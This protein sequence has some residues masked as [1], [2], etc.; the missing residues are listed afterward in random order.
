M[1]KVFI[2]G[3]AGT[4]GLKIKERLSH[5]SDLQL[6]ILPDHLRKDPLAKKDAINS[7]DVTFLCL[8]DD[9]AKESV[10]LLENE[11]TVIIDTS[12]AHRVNDSFVYG[13]P[14]IVGYEKVKKAKKI[15]NPGCHASGFIALIAP[16]VKNGIITKD[17]LLSCTS[18]TGYSGGGKN[19]IADYEEGNNSLNEA[20]RL[21][22]LTQNHKHLK[23]MAHFTLLETAPLFLPI[24]SNF[25]SGMQVTVPL[26]VNQINGDMKIISDIYKECYNGPVVK[27]VENADENGFMS[28]N[29]LSGTDSMEIT[30]TGNQDK[31]LLTARYDNLGKGASGSAI[32]NMNIVLGVNET[33]G[34]NLAK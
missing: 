33:I 10:G 27:F 2:D 5:R 14:E 12:T 26:F 17:A 24:V 34:L 13:F 32:Q 3:S 21:Y 18:L 11:N 6:I 19:M 9:A 1:T 16:L 31:I 25:Y 4:T 22:G 23:E 7:S 29:K 8:P 30:L 28:A 15:A 20:P